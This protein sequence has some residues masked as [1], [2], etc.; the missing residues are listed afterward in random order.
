MP[1]FENQLAKRLYSSRF[2]SS[3]KVEN[4]TLNGE[5][6]TVFRSHKRLPELLWQMEEYFTHHIEIIEHHIGDTETIVK[7]KFLD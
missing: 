5:T 6:L 2:D 4:E 1:V 7:F 3:V